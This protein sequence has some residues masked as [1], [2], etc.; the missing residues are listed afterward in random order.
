MD[1]APDG[2]PEPT[3]EIPVIAFE[4][5]GC[6][7]EPFAAMPTMRF[8]LGVSEPT[9]REVYAVTLTAQVNFDPARRGYDDETKAE[10]IELFGTPDR[11]PATTR[12]FLWKN[13]ETMVHSFVGATTFGIAIPCTADLEMTAT[14]YV[15]AL[16]DGE[17]PL[18][19]H[20]SGRVMY[21]AAGGCVQQ[22]PIP[23]STM[24]EYKMPVSAW[25]AMVDHHHGN[26]GFIRLNNETLGD[27]AHYKAS[28]GHHS[29]DL[30]VAEL[31]TLAETDTEEVNS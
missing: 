23:W 11:W 5:L 25:K 15:S 9:G 4:V 14:R 13:V 29:F 20:F 26:S 3:N 28:R 24:C 7:H 10:L 27:L 17:V 31:L 30:C 8:E 19:F 6:T 21:P 22:V 12:S 18:T 2:P 1:G 16:P